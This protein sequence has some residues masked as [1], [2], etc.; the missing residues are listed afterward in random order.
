M[1]Q[2]QVY[3]PLSILAVL[4][5]GIALVYALVMVVCVI[6]ALAKGSP[7]ILEVWT[8]VF[9]LLAVL[10]SL[11]AWLQIQGSE[12]TLGGRRLALAGIAVSLVVG[13]GYWAYF[14]ATYIAIRQKADSVAREWMTDVGKGENEAAFWWALEP[15]KRPS[16]LPADPANDPAFRK[17]LETRFNIPG[18]GSSLVGLFSQFER[19][20]LIHI[21]RQAGPDAHIESL[22]VSDWGYLPEGYYITLDYRLTTEEAAYDITITLHGNQA[23]HQEFEGRQWFIVFPKAGLHGEPRFT[24]NGWKTGALRQESRNFLEN[25]RARLG[26]GQVGEAFLDTCDAKDRDRRRQP[27]L[28]RKAGVNAM[29]LGMTPCNPGLTQLYA[30]QCLSTDGDQMARET[31]EGYNEFTEGR[32]IHADPKRFWV[33]EDL[34]REEVLKDVKGLFAKPGPDLAS[35]LDVA[36]SMMPVAREDNGRYQVLHS[37][38]MRLDSKKMFVDG[39]AY[40][41]C[42][43]KAVATGPPA[44][45]QLARIELVRAKSI[46]PNQQ[47]PA[48]L[49]RM[50][51]PGG[52]GMPGMPGAPGMPGGPPSNPGGP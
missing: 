21:L 47:G 7:W 44:A 51:R 34:Q 22:G 30:L 12:G 52:P 46:P 35:S 36:R 2:R 5:L 33:P 42:D 1:E 19:S 18:E 9:P 24:E 40:V 31:L 10:I 37:F 11:V 8:V 14:L 6:I 27:I 25:W 16:R 28:E 17:D 38:T 48:G 3:Q 29:V 4:G 43:S 23:Q 13:L 45:W 49:R 41:E 32:L 20:E 15:L 26:T 39:I 50:V